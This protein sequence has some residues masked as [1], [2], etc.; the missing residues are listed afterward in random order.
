MSEN[1][2]E[3]WKDKGNE[4]IKQKN[5]DKGLE[6]YKIA[7]EIDPDYTPA[8]HN[9]GQVYKFLGDENAYKSCLIKETEIL[10]GSKKSVVKDT[11]ELLGR[12]SDTAK[13]GTRWVA[14]ELL[15]GKHRV[16]IKKLIIGEFDLDGLKKMCLFYNISGPS[17]S[18]RKHWENYVIENL[19]RIAHNS[20]NR[21]R[22]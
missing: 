6:Y 10:N 21:P 1:T 8:W 18:T 22:H 4:E 11:V 9:L 15:L 14:Y 5:Y 19:K 13:A 12:L 17:Y 2:P 7:I 20:L 3:Y 16:H